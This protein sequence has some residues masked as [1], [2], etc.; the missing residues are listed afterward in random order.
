[1]QVRHWGRNGDIPVVGDFDGDLINDFVVVR[2]DQAGVTPNYQWF[3]LQSNFDFGFGL[4]VPWGV[5]GDRV[6]T[7]DFDGNAKSD[8]AVYRPTNGTWHVIPSDAQNAISTARQGF[9]WGL[10]GDIPQP[11]DY[12]GDRRTDFAVFRPSNATWYL[13]NSNNGTYSSFSIVPWG[14]A[15]DEPASSPYRITNP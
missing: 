14:Q 13:S 9:A 4:T 5:A 6:V 12:D 8:I 2:P 1:L 10:P 15:T 7:G 3:L 11:A